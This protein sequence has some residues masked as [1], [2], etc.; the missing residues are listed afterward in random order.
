MKLHREGYLI[1][2]IAMT[3]LTAVQFGNFYLLLF[4]GWQWLFW[5]LTIGA[6]VMAYLVIQFFRIPKIECILT[7]NI[8][9]FKLCEI[10]V[11]TSEEFLNL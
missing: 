10:D 2:I 7:R 1:I 8:K 4:T 3:L 5:L 6:L 9:D 11:Y